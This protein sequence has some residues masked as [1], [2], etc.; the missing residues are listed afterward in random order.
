MIDL[1]SDT[2]T[3]PTPAMRRAMAEAEVGD[4]VYREDPTVNRLEQRAAEIAGKEAALFVPTGTMGNTI[5][6]KL[7]TQHGQEVICDSLAHILNWELSMTAW[8][9]GCLVRP[10]TTTDGIL[11]WDRIRPHVRP[12]G[13]LAASTALVE[14]EN[15]CNMAG[16]AVYPL[17]V[18]DE[19]CG[20]AHALGLKVHMDGA[21]VFNA[22]IASGTPVNRIA[23]NVD[24]IMF[25]LSKA[26][27][28]P[29]GSMLAGAAE[30]MDRAR[31]Y[32]KCLGGG[33]RQAGILAAAGLIALEEMPQRL[34]EDHANARYLAAE[35]ARIPGVRLTPSNVETNIVILDLSEA[36]I[37][38]PEFCARLKSQ[39]VLMG[40]APGGRVRAVTHFDVSRADCERAAAAASQA[41]GLPGRDR[42]RAVRLMPN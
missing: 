13:A 4:D 38:Q 30:A 37:T 20:N 14:I 42:E 31:P 16:G 23:A 41:V 15:T 24:T 21:R 32:R 39:G 26:L 9:S 8:F 29:A 28:A 33:M 5:A 11:R 19:I 34:A 35:L 3:K 6:I 25:C 2:V 17:E 22:S 7:H 36:G 12:R 18:I 27:G 1:R 40:G 10:V